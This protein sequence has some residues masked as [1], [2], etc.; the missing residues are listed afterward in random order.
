MDWEAISK[1]K[2]T[3]IFLMGFANLKGLVEKLIWLGK[4]IDTPVAIIANGA[5]SK[6]KTVVGSLAN[7]IA[8]TEQIGVTNQRFLIVG[9][10]LG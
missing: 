10:L 2:G 9:M 3:L 7:I 1:L 8:Q 6:Q 4:P 5:T